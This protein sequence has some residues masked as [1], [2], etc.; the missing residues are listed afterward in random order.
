MS[1][2]E[3]VK[4]L[5]QVQQKQ[6]CWVILDDIW[7]IEAWNSL[8]AAFPKKNTG[9]KI[10]LTSRNK[11]VSWHADPR[12]F[13]YEL[14]HLNDKWSLE[15]LDKIIS[16]RKDSISKTRMEKLGKEMI[17][18]CGG[19]PLAITIL[20][21]LLAAKQ[22]QEDWE[23]V[24]RYVKSHKENFGVN[25]VFALSY[26]D[27]PCNLKPCFLYLGLFLKG[28]EIR[29]KE[30]KRM[31]MAEGF[32]PQIQHGGDGEDAM[33]DEG[34]RYLQEL[35]QRCMVHAGKIGSLGRI[36]TC[37][38]HDLMHDFC[39]AKAQRENFLL[40]SNICSL[41]LSEEHI[42][43]IRR[44][45]INWKSSDECLQGIKLKKYPY[46]RSLLYSMLHL[47]HV[48]VKE[49]CFKNFKLLRVLNLE[50]YTRKLPEDIGLLIHLKFLSIKNSTMTSLPSS[51]G[52]LRCLQTLDLRSHAMSVPNVFKK[53]EQLRHLYLPSKYEVSEK[54]ELANLC[55]LQTLENVQPKTIQMAT[56]FRLNRLRVLGVWRY[57]KEPAQDAIQI[58]SSCPHIHK[59]SLRM[60]INK[61]LEVHQFSPNLAK[62]TL[63]NTRLNVDPMAT[64]ENLPNLKILRLLHKT[65]S[66]DTMLDHFAERYLDNSKGGFPLL[67]S[68]VICRLDKLKEWRVEKGAMPGLCRLEIVACMCLNTIPDALRFIKNLRELEI[69]WMP[70]SFKDRLIKGGTDFYKVQHVPSL[71]FQCCIL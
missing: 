15:L 14:Q 26:N 22:T 34:E 68:L 53:M 38:V 27:L 36:K 2:A 47:N 25:K 6:K 4:K 44:L 13:L 70:K 8:C 12:G 9:S 65:F 64:F 10:L 63:R 24:L 18:Y 21:G 48:Y 3:L 39:L 19:L 59:L 54:L 1:D 51:L 7:T 41:G 55:Y 50:N 49:L 5:R 69:I 43:K 33:E 60:I 46:L 11:D 67:Q 58:V 61:L 40:M 20:G 35:V 57:Y 62:L 42:G 52:N 45:A 32:I 66:G 29:S 31:W 30:L 23:N 56:S 17:G 28:F 71:V 16:H 37:R